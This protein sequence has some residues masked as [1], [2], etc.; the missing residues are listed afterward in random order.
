MDK[1]RMSSL[2]RYLTI[3]M[4]EL[5]GQ[6]GVGYSDRTNVPSLNSKTQQWNI[7][8]GFLPSASPKSVVRN[9]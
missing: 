9:Q 4:F 8:I 5:G 6:E 3:K 7:Q 1:R 2:E